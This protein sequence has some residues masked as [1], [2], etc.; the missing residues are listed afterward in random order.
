[1]IGTKSVDGGSNNQGVIHFTD[2]IMNKTL[3]KIKKLHYIKSMVTHLRPIE[4]KN[5][6]N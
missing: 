1:M 5:G 4:I 6:S 2:N 3:L